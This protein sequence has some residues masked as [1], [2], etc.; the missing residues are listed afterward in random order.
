[1]AFE[2]NLGQ[3]LFSPTDRTPMKMLFQDITDHKERL[4][5]LL[6]FLETHIAFCENMLENVHLNSFTE[7][8]LQVDAYYEKHKKELDLTFAD[9]N[10]PRTFP[11]KI[12][13]VCQFQSSEIIVENESQWNLVYDEYVKYFLPQIKLLQNSLP[14]QWPQYLPNLSSIDGKPRLL[15]CNAKDYKTITGCYAAFTKRMDTLKTTW[16]MQLRN[17]YKVVECMKCFSTENGLEE[18]INQMK[19]DKPGVPEKLPMG[20]KEKPKKKGKGKDL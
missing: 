9:P 6:G 15:I 7:R 16:I 20:S 5:E 10:Q 18:R 8:N 17:C 12:L 1:M 2:R 14:T 19:K 11:L 13:N 3:V 4:E